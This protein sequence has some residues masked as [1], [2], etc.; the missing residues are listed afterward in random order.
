[1]DLSTV[2]VFILAGGFGTRISEETHLR[3][4]PMIEIGDTPILLHI[5]RSY[6]S[7][8]FTNFVICAGYRAWEIKDY[9]LNYQYR[10]NNIVIDHRQSL[11]E[12]PRYR[13]GSIGQERWRVMVLDTGLDVMT[14]A[15][16]ARAFDDLAAEES[17][18]HF[19]VT[20]GDGV[21]DVNL[22]AEMDFHLKHGKTGTVLGVQP[23]SR[24]G[25]L[26]TDRDGLVENF[27]EKP[28]SRLALI[29]GGF[30]FFKK[31]FRRLLNTDK[32]CILERAPLEKLAGE[33]QLMMFEHRGFWHCMDTLRDKTHL[34]QLWDSGRAP[35]ASANS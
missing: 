19:A 21:C 33:R 9:F 15:R 28:E 13:K 10:Q 14:G 18:E 32:S 3:P 7:H 6:Y 31:D 4:K 11:S 5:M 29:N 34:Q 23:L 27:I 16:I 20:Y 24:F 26:S 22:K 17:F 25:E 12:P 1:M 35:W 30:F 8:G 2:P